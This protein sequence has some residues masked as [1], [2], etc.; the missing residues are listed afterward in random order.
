MKKKNWRL[1]GRI[2][3]VHG[4][5]AEFGRAISVHPSTI[6]RVVNG[7]LTL[8]PTE[9]RRWASALSADEEE[10]FPREAAE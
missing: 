2:H 4:S 9:R 5:G 6:S 8:N 1:W 7:H 10:I 3:E